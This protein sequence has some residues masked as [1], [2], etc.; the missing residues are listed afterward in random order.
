MQYLVFKT[1]KKEWV[2]KSKIA[3][4]LAYCNLDTDRFILKYAFIQIKQASQLE[5]VKVLNMHLRAKESLQT[6]LNKQR[7]RKLQRFFN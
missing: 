1:L 6:I 7:G 4:K 3:K 5:Y 2:L